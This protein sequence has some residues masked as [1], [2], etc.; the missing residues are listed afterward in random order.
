MPGDVICVLD[1]GGEF[2]DSLVPPEVSLSLATALEVGEAAR[3]AK[4]VSFP[5]MHHSLKKRSK[6]QEYVTTL[7]LP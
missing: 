2:R 1:A 6:M 3:T 7:T 5:F 4:G